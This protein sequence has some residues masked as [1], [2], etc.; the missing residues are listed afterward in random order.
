M[1]GKERGEGRGK[2]GRGKEGGGKREGERGEE[3][4][5]IEG[6]GREGKGR[7][8]RGRKRDR[9]GRRCERW[10]IKWEG[11]MFLIHLWNGC[12]VYILSVSGHI[13]WRGMEGTQP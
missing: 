13:G 12:C 10:R 4:R 11:A 5:G 3:G 6:R 2:E 8:G 7:E 9:G 1:R